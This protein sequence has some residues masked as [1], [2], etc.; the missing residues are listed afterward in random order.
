MNLRLSE[1]AGRDLEDISTY[2]SRD[3]PRAAEAWIMRLLERIEQ[4][5]LQPR[6]GRVVPEFKHSDIREVFWRS[7]RII[8]LIEPESLYVFRII[9]GHRRLRSLE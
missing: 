4:A 1:A 9:E 2:I 7:Y 5:C 3:N 6:G 8:Y